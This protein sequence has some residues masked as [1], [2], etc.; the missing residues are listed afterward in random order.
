MKA[1]LSNLSSFE[2][3]VA[4]ALSEFRWRESKLSDFHDIRLCS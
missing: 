1:N 4:T 3:R 2:L